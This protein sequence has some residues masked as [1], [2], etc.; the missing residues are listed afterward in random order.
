[1]PMDFTPGVWSWVEPDTS[2]G[3]VGEHPLQQITD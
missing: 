2:V 1:M 3:S